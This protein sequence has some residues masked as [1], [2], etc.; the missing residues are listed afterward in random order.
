MDFSSDISEFDFHE[1][2]MANMSLV[3]GNWKRCIIIMLVKIIKMHA[4][5]KPNIGSA[6]LHG[7]TFGSCK[8]IA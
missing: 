8:D 4:C 5:R 6:S 7:Y 3:A 2:I 1:K